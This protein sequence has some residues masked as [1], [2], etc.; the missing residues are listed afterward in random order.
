MSSSS[1]WFRDLFGFDERR[2]GYEHV[3]R[4]FQLEL[5]EQT[6]ILHSTCNSRSFP[7]G[8]FTCKSVKELREEAHHH[9]RRLESREPS[10]IEI[11]H[12]VVEDALQLHYRYPGSVIQA[13]SQL[14]CL[15]FSHPDIIPEHGIAGYVDDHTQGPACAI[16]CAGGTVYRNYLVPLRGGA[17]QTADRQ[18]NNLAEVE[19]I[20]GEP[21]LWEVKNGYC[22]S[23]E[24]NLS[25]LSSALQGNE[26]DV[27]DAIKAEYISMLE[28]PTK[29]ALSKLQVTR[30]LPLLKF[31]ALP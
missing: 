10:Q 13:A 11:V 31:T 21:K 29:I 12:D 8:R 26:D 9:L 22:F 6:I 25:R 19:L 18:I 27:T 28:S 20:L 16:A 15:E 5:T 1:S 17:G 24:A 23:T 7:I 30:R 3:Q 4:N 2:H 14:N